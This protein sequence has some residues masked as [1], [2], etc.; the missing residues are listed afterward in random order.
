MSPSYAL[1]NWKNFYKSRSGSGPD[2][3]SGLVLGFEMVSCLH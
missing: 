2:M 1:I 3:D